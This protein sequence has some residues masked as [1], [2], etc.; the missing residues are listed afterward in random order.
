MIAHPP[1]EDLDI[2]VTVDS[3]EDEY[4]E[5]GEQRFS[6]DSERE[7][8]DD[9]SKD[10]SSQSSGESSEHISTSE[11]EVGGACPA[12]SRNQSKSLTEEEFTELR[13]DPQFERLLLEVLCHSSKRSPL[14]KRKK[15]LRKGKPVVCK[16]PRKVHPGTQN[17]KI[18]S[19]SDTTIYAPAL[20]N[21]QET[22]ANNLIV[23][24]MI[25]SH[26]TSGFLSTISECE[27]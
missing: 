3:S 9:E 24:N 20:A 26:T 15:H 22:I 2:Q 27:K 10:S 11:D 7:I 5:A 12:K 13:D 25:Q 19:P 23:P 21:G 8:S 4:D 17:H 6:S 14:S 18:K 16:T 1:Q